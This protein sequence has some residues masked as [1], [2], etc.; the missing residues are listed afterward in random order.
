MFVAEPVL[1]EADTAF[2]KKGWVDHSYARM[3]IRADTSRP[4]RR[5]R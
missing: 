1:Q 4:N 5:Q 2:R 3:E